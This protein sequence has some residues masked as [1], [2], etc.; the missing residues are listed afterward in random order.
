[1]VLYMF[2]IFLIFF[3]RREKKRGN[4]RGLVCLLL[5]LLER[6]VGWWISNWEKEVAGG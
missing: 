3:I 2:C 6:G 1:M 4:V 5:G